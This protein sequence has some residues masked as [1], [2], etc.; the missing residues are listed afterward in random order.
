MKRPSFAAP[1]TTIALAVLLAMAVLTTSARAADAPPPVS[2]EAAIR[3]AGERWNT[4]FEALNVD[5]LAAFYAADAILMPETAQAVTGPKGIRGFLKVYA[6]L[7]TESGYKP[8]IDSRIDV[9][10]S[11]NL[12]YRSGYYWVTDKAKTKIDSGKWLEIWRKKDGKWLITK[13]MWN[14]DILP[15]FPPNAYTTGSIPAE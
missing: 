3:K 14:S 2:D 6:G 7:M 12:G 4:A 13:N 5:A 9:G 8:Y 11:G 15:M 10:V 1:S